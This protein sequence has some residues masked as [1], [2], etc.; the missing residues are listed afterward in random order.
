[1]TL[2]KLL[3]LLLL[4][5]PFTA[6]AAVA[7]VQ[8]FS[9]TNLAFASSVTTSSVTVTAGNLIICT[10]EADVV[11]QDGITM[12]DSKGNTWA[13]LVSRARAATFDLEVWYAIAT[14]GGSSY[15]VTATDNGGGVDSLIICEEW[16]GT[17]TVSVADQSAAADGTGSTDLNSGA[18]GV[19]SQANEIVIGAGVASGDVTMTL[20]AGYSNLTEVNSSFSTLAFESKVVSAA[21]A[22]TATLTSGTLG[23]WVMAVGTFKE[24]ASAA[25]TPP[26]VIIFGDL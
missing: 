21:G 17:A 3:P 18:S 10:A 12:T 24:A 7:R 26:R 11:A 19:T 23:S 8:A 2:L 22:Q 25:V 16:S 13:R 15:T 5:F 4:L 6:E 9:G 20:G 14:V 1:M